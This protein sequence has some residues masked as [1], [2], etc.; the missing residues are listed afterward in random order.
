[1]SNLSGNK[2]FSGFT[3]FEDS[4]T[5]SVSDD[6]TFIVKGA[7][8]TSYISSIT[9]ILGDS[10][11]TITNHN[12]NLTD[13]VSL[14]NDIQTSIISLS[15]HV[16]TNIL[17][18]SKT[19]HRQIQSL[20]FTF[21]GLAENLSGQMHGIMD[22]MNN[23][24]PPPP[25]SSSSSVTSM[26]QDTPN[27]QLT[28][29]SGY[30]V[31]VTN[32]NLVINAT[33]YSSPSLITD[34][35][36]YSPYSASIQ[37]ASGTSHTG[38]SCAYVQRGNLVLNFGSSTPV[39]TLTAFGTYT[40]EFFFK[41]LSGI[42]NVQNFVYGSGFGNPTI[43]P[44]RFLHTSYIDPNND[45][46][47]AFTIGD[48]SGWTASGVSTQI[49]QRDTWYHLAF[50]KSNTNTFEYFLNGQ[51]QATLINTTSGTAA[52]DEN[53]RY[54]TF[55]AQ[56]PANT[57]QYMTFV[58]Y[59]DT[60]R[61]SSKARYSGST[62]TVPI[63]ASSDRY[64]LDP[65]TVYVNYFSSGIVG[66]ITF[67]G[68]GNESILYSAP[69]KKYGN[70]QLKKLKNGYT[71]YTAYMDSNGNV[72]RNASDERLKTNIT[73]ITSTL[74][75][76]HAL[77]PV[78]FKWKDSDCLD[79]GFIAQQVQRDFESGLVFQN[80]NGYLGFHITKLIPFLVKG[81]QELST[82]LDLLKQKYN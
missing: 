79:W 20:S 30:S 40:I 51:K 71:T 53:L 46:K 27:L 78:Q 66:S 41:Q 55:G 16:Q 82:K 2:S 65:Y 72:N 29:S 22:N 34:N 64:T 52:I 63:S 28:V 57:T 54:H 42:P 80:I 73:P 1:M 67:N 75:K 19:F 10:N 4:D 3:I 39:T 8:L 77:D 45:N 59:F 25:S 70:F 56:H 68:S 37:L 24:L 47:M 50:Q 43:N 12:D 18:L 81:V 21:H 7:P 9:D 49:I 17:N 33:S 35:T 58:G 61:F 14:T 26:T 15:S 76:I 32:G 5:F 31:K 36:S 13:A 69:A 74:D 6:W 38:P 48:G 44:Y 23:N 11:V 62:Y 60:L